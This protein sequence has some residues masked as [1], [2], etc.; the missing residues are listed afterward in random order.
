MTTTRSSTGMLAC[1]LL[2][3]ACCA[4]VWPQ[5]HAIAIDMASGRGPKALR[6]VELL[7]L[8]VRAADALPSPRG[9]CRYRFEIR[10]IQVRDFGKPGR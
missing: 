7:R 1:D 2:A 6:Q 4:M 10:V 3:D 5:S 8:A 9:N